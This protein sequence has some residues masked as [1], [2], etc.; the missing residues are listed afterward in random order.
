MTL[1]EAI[2]HCE[3]KAKAQRRLA[4]YYHHT[5]LSENDEY[6]NGMCQSCLKCANEHEQLAEWLKEL[7][8]YKEAPKGDLISRS[9]LKEEVENLIGYSLSYEAILNAI[10]NAPTVYEKL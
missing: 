6:R 10:D 4:E 5:R 3:D 9:A 1:D 2:K 8:A 7:K